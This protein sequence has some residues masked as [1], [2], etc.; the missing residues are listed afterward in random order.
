MKQVILWL[1]IGLV[2]M[3]MTSCESKQEILDQ[4]EQEVTAIFR[5]VMIFSL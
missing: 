2:T 5:Y 4:M 1:A 3:A